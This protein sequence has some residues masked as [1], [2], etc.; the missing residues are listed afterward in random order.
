MVDKKRVAIVGAG[1]V[2]L[3]AAAHVQER[4]MEPIVLEAGPEAAHAVRQWQH[5]QLF[6]R[7]EYNVDKSAARLLVSTGWNS[8][9]P[10]VYPTG[11]ELIERYL[12][13]LATKSA[14]RG[15]IRTSSRVTAISRVGFDKA[16]TR[17]REH[18]AF[19]IRYQNGKGSEVLRAD[20]VI[21]SPAP[22]FLPIQPD[23]T[24][25]RHS[26]NR[27]TLGRLPMACPT[28]SGPNAPA[29][30]ARPPPF[31]APAIRRSAR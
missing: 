23:P 26:E 7:W 16:R 29:M 12:E 4:G 31:S 13:P 19:E 22:G 6:S 21:D 2:G 18:A 11:G 14:L 27:S 9:D 15:A 1:P 10:Q 24:A 5:V 3:A 30:P 17:G 20:A 8:P 25:C 28:F